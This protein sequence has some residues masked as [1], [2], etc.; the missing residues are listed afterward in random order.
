MTM[1][2]VWHAL[3]AS[4]NALNGSP[5]AWALASLAVNLGAR[6][7]TTDFLSPEQQSALAAPLARRAIVLCMVFLVTHNLL[8]SILITGVLVVVLEGLLR[9]TSRFCILAPLGGCS[10]RGTA[11]GGNA[12]EAVVAAQAGGSRALA[13]FEHAML[14]A[15]VRRVGP[16]ESLDASNNAASAG[17]LVEGRC[18]GAAAAGGM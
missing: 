12:A 9:P 8:L 3:T 16:T 2:A 5:V 14:S 7:V 15:A 4:T 17:H 10:A 1:L 18:M 13:R 11:G 6:H